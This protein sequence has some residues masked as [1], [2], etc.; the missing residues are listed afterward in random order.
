MPL[1]ELGLRKLWS[2]VRGNSNPVVE[3]E[4]HEEEEEPPVRDH[5][6]RIPEPP[7][8]QVWPSQEDEDNAN[9]KAPEDSGITS[10]DPSSSSP[11]AKTS[12]AL[13][14]PHHALR[15]H[16]AGPRGERSLVFTLRLF[17]YLVITCNYIIG[18]TSEYFFKF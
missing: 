2:A 7:L 10:V 1:R 18:E 5:T 6:I 14:H 8:L 16:S 13:L 9:A 4:P 15:R 17:F 3:E 11:A 12:P